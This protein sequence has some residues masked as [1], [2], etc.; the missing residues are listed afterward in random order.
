MWLF[1]CRTSA[2]TIERTIKALAWRNMVRAFHDYRSICEVRPMSVRVPTH[3]APTYPGEM[4]L[5]EFLV[6]MGITQRALADAMV[7]SGVQDQLLRE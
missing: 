2:M 6:P 7:V 5:E 1:Y 4:L 3:R